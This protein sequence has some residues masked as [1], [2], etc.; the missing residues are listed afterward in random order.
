MLRKRIVV[1]DDDPDLRGILLERFTNRWH[2]VEIPEMT[3]SS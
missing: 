3:L 2:R 1:V